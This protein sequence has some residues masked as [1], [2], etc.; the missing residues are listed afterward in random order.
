MKGS[1]NDAV[2]ACVPCGIGR[3]GIWE[4]SVMRSICYEFTV[5][6]NVNPLFV[7]S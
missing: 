2:S 3:F 6:W 4:T 7:L 1:S 5:S